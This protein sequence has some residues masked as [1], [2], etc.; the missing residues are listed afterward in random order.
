METCQHKSCYEYIQCLADVLNK[1]FLHRH[2]K[3]IQLV[4]P[5]EVMTAD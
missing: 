1:M 2:M 5:T 3:I 4:L